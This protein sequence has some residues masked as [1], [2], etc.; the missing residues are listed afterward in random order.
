MYIKQ[1]NL[2][3]VYSWNK[4]LLL[5]GLVMLKYDRRTSLHAV[6]CK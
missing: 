1:T 5:K 4:M 2:K 3:D 6:Q